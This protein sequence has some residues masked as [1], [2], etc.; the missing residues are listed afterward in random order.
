MRSEVQWSGDSDYARAK[1]VLAENTLF[2]TKDY[3]SAHSIIQSTALATSARHASSG[4]SMSDEVAYTHVTSSTTTRNC[5]APVGSVRLRIKS[6]SK[7]NLEYCCDLDSTTVD[8]RAD[9]I[10]GVH[11]T[12]VKPI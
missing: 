2:K 11:V 10:S 7:T 6:M 3:L 1:R 4:D 9:C 8:L 5:L 12:P